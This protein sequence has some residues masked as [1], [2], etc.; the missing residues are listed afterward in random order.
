[1]K[2]LIQFPLKWF[3]YYEWVGNYDSG[4]V[5]HESGLVIMKV[6]WLL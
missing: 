2:G 1:M 4:L 6:G 3:G 5:C